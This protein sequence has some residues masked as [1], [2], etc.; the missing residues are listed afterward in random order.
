MALGHNLRVVAIMRS[1]A[2]GLQ[3]DQ[4]CTEMNG[5]RIEA[6]V[7]LLKD[8]KPGIQIFDNLDILIVDVNPKDSSEIEMLDSIVN[9]LFPNNPVVGTAPDATIQDVR[10]LM[11]VGVVDFI[12]QPI[13]NA[14]LQAALSL[15]ASKRK[16]ET[17]PAAAKGKVFSFIKGGG[18]VGATT[19]A[20]Q[21]GC[22]LATDFSSS[23]KQACLLDLDIQVGTTALYLDL[24]NRIG[25]G[26]LME[27]PERLDSELLAGATL[28]H[29]SGL[30]VIAA[31][32]EVMPLET[33][34]PEFVSA[35]LG[36]VR[37]D[38]DVTLIDLP[39]AWT[40]GSY[41][42]LEGSDI[43]YLITQLSV[44][45]VRQTRHQLNTLRMQ[46]LTDTE[47]RVV[48]NRYEKGWGKAVQLKEAEKALGC[49]IDHCIA[50]DFK[51]VSEALNQGIAISRI[52]SRSKIEKGIREMI[53]G[54][55]EA[56]EERAVQLGAIRLSA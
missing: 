5:T 26:E 55:I 21:A 22:L 17:E 48:L 15:A 8:I 13:T 10:Q 52:K 30:K 6:H 49:K 7:G 24:D 32:R 34:S 40:E 51:T 12:P 19:I 16:K 23:D 4:E 37:R 41:T 36:V 18:G 43:I 29:D 1:E 35:I 3:L 53:E 38:F 2:A 28:T 56:S 39:G 45:G 44:A 27:T 14:D 9:N 50:N 31:P 11:R 42:A 20:V 33:M 54:A 47:V 46:G 25:V